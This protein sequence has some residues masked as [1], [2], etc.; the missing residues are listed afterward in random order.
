MSMGIF[1]LAMLGTS[2]GPEPSFIQMIILSGELPLIIIFILSIVI[3]VSIGIV[4][5]KH[6]R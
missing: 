4:I 1:G 2:G 5:S 6:R 3:A